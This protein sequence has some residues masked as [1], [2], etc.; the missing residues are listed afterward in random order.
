MVALAD[1]SYI[2]AISDPNTTITDEMYQYLMNTRPD[3]LIS[4]LE[5]AEESWWDSVKHVFTSDKYTSLEREQ[6]KNIYKEALGRY[7]TAYQE[8]LKQREILTDDSPTWTKMPFQVTLGDEFETLA[9]I[10]GTLMEY[11]GPISSTN[12]TAYTRGA[13]HKD[14]KEIA[15]DI[16]VDEQMMTKPFLKDTRMGYSTAINCL[17]QFNRDDDIVHAINRSE[18]QEGNSNAIEDPHGWY[19]LGRVYSNYLEA[20]QTICYISFGTAKFQN[21]V[22]FYTQAADNSIAKLNRL[23]TLGASGIFSSLFKIVNGVIEIVLWVPATLISVVST[24]LKKITTFPVN[25]FYDMRP[26]MHLYYMYVDEI[27]T[28]W[29]VAAG[30]Y[31]GGH[32]DTGDQLLD[33]QNRKGVNKLNDLYSQAAAT[34]ENLPIS[35]RMTGPSIWSILTKKVVSYNQSYDGANIQKIN[36]FEEMAKQVIQTDIKKYDYSDKSYLAPWNGAVLFNSES[37]DV[38]TKTALGA[39]QFVAFRLEKSTD[40]SESWSNSTQ[41]SALAQ[42][43]NSMLNT[44]YHTGMD[45][46]F[47]GTDSAA[48]GEGFS[49]WLWKFISDTMS[50]A[51][52]ILNLVNLGEVISTGVFIDVP[53]Q[54]SGSSFNKSQSFNF[55]L[56][57]PY[58]DITSI[59]QSIIVPLAMILAG[60]IPRATGPNSY[61]QP[62]L[63]RAYCRGIFAIPLGIIDSISVKR[64]SSEFGW[65]HSGLPTCVDVSISIKDLSSAMYMALHQSWLG[66]KGVGSNAYTD[67]SFSEYLMTLAG[68]GTYERLSTGQ[69]LIRR[70]QLASHKLRNN[71]FD[72]THWQQLAGNNALTQMAM[73]VVHP[74]TT[75]WSTGTH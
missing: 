61:T 71:I 65:T 44:G 30:I 54:W 51:K 11:Y 33:E 4:D 52:N 10:Y 21:I 31:N 27:I 29:L 69:R 62:F 19:G 55:Q 39:T 46:G 5:N 67:N 26:T 60:A 17:W 24:L 49:G 6:V 70:A 43:V 23:G 14:Y 63:C 56:R 42:K 35:M 9:D 58:G 16:N 36:H 28:N 37:T 20:N 72:V 66:S 47:Q 38:L 73:G 41:P 40:A 59:Y 3:L 22:N 13:G 64:G 32:V 75:A 1:S 45:L 15:K 57:A 8:S 68:T 12:R 18:P 74:L 25:R 48:P 7:N 53:E 34:P 50:G 2:R